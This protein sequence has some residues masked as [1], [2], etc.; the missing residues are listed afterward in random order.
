MKNNRV[1]L[2]LCALMVQASCVA[3]NIAF[4]KD[5]PDPK[6]YKV[7]GLEG[8]DAT[9]SYVDKVIGQRLIPDDIEDGV[10]LL[11]REEAVSRDV[12]KAL[13]AKGY[14]QANVHYEDGADE[15]TYQI[16]SG[17][18][19]RIEK[20]TVSPKSFRPI[21][22]SKDV[23]AGDV[24]D[25]IKILGEQKKILQELQEK[26]C[27][28]D[29]DI[30]H[31]VL[32]NPD[33]NRAQ[34]HFYIDQGADA[35][36]GSVRFTGLERIDVDY[37]HKL[38]PWKQGDCFR[39]DEIRK[40]RDKVL[41]TGLV[42]RIDPV[43]PE[44]SNALS[45]IPVEFE[46]QE[47]AQRSI[48]AGVSYY[49]DEG[50][51]AVLGWEHRNFLGSGEK[52]K[53]DL[54]LSMLEQSLKANF[55]KEEF[56][57]KDQSLS[58][59]A[60]LD[61]EDTDAF[62]ELGIGAGFG[63]NR[64]LAN[65]WSARVGS[66]FKLTRINEENEDTNNFAL[67]TPNVSVSYDSRDDALDPTKGIVFNASLKPFLDVLG[68]SA[69]FVK[70]QV[71]MRAYQP[72]HE[73]IILAGRTKIG[74]LSGTGNND[75]PATERFYAG[76]GGSV[77]GFGFQEVGPFEDGDPEGGRSVVEGAAELR[78]KFTDTIGAVTFA[79]FAQVDEGTS[80]G[81]DNLSV[82]VGAGLRYYSDFGPLRFD[83]GVPVTGKENADQNF[84][85]Y[86]S[87]GQAF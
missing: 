60:S 48:K 66:D 68:E 12:L 42:S 43:F 25:A 19:T 29:L 41:G 65:N 57:R 38:V 24:L 6:H 86:I 51:G 44:D 76:G 45:S 3:D 7:V 35:T 50:V 16:K 77:R 13:W 15:G 18:P 40:F 73:R 22:T 72:L 1:L 27:A 36:F 34:I 71:G 70:A 23:Q 74:V 69:P 2:L 63:I 84:Q 58:I 87:I 81:F 55:T 83:I 32:L 59:N 37:L 52:L 20:I 47:R 26:S 17:E 31:K 75:I 53:A 9:K 5:R 11:Y 78:F 14:Y 61:R 85:I 82:G 67:F 39:H 49:T 21:I 46:V 30:S 33:T 80:S 79:D 64:K 4:W 28:F 8:D 56:L 10:D 54:T 62:E